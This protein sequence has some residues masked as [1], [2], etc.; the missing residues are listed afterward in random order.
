M[1]VAGDGENP[2]PTRGAGMVGMLEDVAGA[3]DPR[4]LAVP[5]AEDPVVAGAA[6]QI[7]LLRAPDGWK[8]MSCCSRSLP[9][10][11][12]VWSTPASGEPR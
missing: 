2:S 1:I 11:H 6:E 3:V 4:A 5:H 7:E 12:S 8:R 10:F 9:A